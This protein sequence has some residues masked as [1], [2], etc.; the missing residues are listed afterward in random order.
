MEI[1]YL[2][3]KEKIIYCDDTLNLRFIYKIN[4]K[5]LCENLSKKITI[6]RLLFNCNKKFD[7]RS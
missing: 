3:S 2:Y 5:S 4:I 6:I 1:N 7:I